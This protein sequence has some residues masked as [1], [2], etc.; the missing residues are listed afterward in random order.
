M[1]EL[2][3]LVVMCEDLRERVVGRRI[4]AVRS[5]RP[6]ILKTI[7]PPVDD[8]IG[9]TYTQFIKVDKIIAQLIQCDIRFVFRRYFRQTS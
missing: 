8:L 5:V 3:E 9:S 2:P 4:V 7:E 1:P 6:G